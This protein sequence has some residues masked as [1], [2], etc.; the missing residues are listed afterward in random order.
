MG[1][2]VYNKKQLLVSSWDTIF[3]K[4]MVRTAVKLDSQHILSVCR[5]PCELSGQGGKCLWTFAGNFVEEGQ[6]SPSFVDAAGWH[7]S[8][9]AGKVASYTCND[10]TSSSSSYYGQSGE[11][12]AG[13]SS[14]GSGETFLYQ[15]FIA[16]NTYHAVACVAWDV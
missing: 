6:T 11:W 16:C 3:R 12:D 7:G 8:T 4:G 10:W 15:R 13:G 1:S 2:P 14:V 5:F 9:K